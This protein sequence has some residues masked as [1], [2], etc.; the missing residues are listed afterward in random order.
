MS[1]PVTEETARNMLCPL[2]FTAPEVGSCSASFCMA[3]QWQ[4]SA[5]YRARAVPAEPQR[6]YCGIA[7]S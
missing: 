2:S 1:E 7:N 5:E 4:M 6:G 3:W